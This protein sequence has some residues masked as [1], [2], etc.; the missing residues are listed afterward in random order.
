MSLPPPRPAHH[1]PALPLRICRSQVLGALGAQSCLTL[2]DPMDCSPPG[3]S[4]HG[5]SQAGILQW[6][7][8]SS[9]RES[10]RPRSKPHLLRLP[11]L[12]GEFFTTSTTWKVHIPQG[13]RP[14][15]ENTGCFSGPG[16]TLLYIVLAK[17]FVHVFL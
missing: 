12:A 3:S 6:V 2:C 14:V 4:V 9:F 15:S 1:A 11:A 5:I 7:A 13:S 16:T 10:S 17:K 8:I